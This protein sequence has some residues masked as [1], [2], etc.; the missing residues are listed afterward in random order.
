MI[1]MTL[2]ILSIV[3]VGVA[4]LSY[5]GRKLFIRATYYIAPSLWKLSIVSSAVLFT[6]GIAWDIHYNSKAENTNEFAEQ[7]AVIPPPA[8]RQQLFSTNDRRAEDNNREIEKYISS[9][10]TIIAQN[11]QDSEAYKE[12]G[13]AYSNLG[14]YKKALRDLTRAI[15]IHPTSDAFCKRAW[16]HVTVGDKSQAA[17]DATSALKLDPANEDALDAREV[18]CR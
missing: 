13:W 9:L 2:I 4:I 5:Y 7:L 1:P 18:A 14:D 16:V 6:S 3:F 10:D 8:P 17:K 12:R 15:V 11:R